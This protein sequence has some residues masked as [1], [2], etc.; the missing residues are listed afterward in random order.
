MTAPPALFMRIH[1]TAGEAL[2]RQ[3][4][5]RLPETAVCPKQFEWEIREMELADIRR[6]TFFQGHISPA[7]L[8]A[9]LPDLRAFTLMREP[10]ERLLSC[11]FYWKEGAK[12]ACTPFFDKL[13]GLSLLDFLRSE[14]PAIRRVTWNTQARLLAGGQFGGTDGLRQNV[15][16]P[17]LPEADLG[18]EAIRRWTATRSS[19][20]PSGTRRRW[21]RLIRSSTSAIRRRPN[22]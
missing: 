21:R 11:Y 9:A 18:A 12:R 1:K 19:V 6:Y 15:F 4:V 13:R 14:E 17:W 22:G 20:W 2:A 5:E 7:A 16:G 3:I 8:A 10:R